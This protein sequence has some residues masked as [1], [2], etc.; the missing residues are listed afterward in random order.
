MRPTDLDFRLNSNQFDVDDVLMRNYGESMVDQHHDLCNLSIPQIS[1]N[2]SRSG[3]PDLRLNSYERIFEHPSG[4]LSP[5][6]ASS[7]LNGLENNQLK[8]FKNVFDD[9]QCHA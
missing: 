8:V 2:D 3:S 1:L 6:M 7:G 4:L 5:K 9:T